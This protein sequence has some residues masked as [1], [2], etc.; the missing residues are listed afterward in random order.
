MS[1]KKDD[2]KHIIDFQKRSSKK[3]MGIVFYS[4]KSIVPFGERLYA[5]GLGY[6]L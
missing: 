3:V 6:F 5:I 2:F 1:V 4:G